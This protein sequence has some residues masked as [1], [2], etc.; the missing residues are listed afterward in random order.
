MLLMLACCHEFMTK[1]QDV[2]AQIFRHTILSIGA[3]TKA[4]VKV[5]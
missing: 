5:S 1:I 3:D 4:C 2:A